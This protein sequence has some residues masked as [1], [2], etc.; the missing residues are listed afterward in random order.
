[1]QS[2]FYLLEEGEAHQRAGKLNLAL[3]RFHGVIKACPSFAAVYH[4]VL[5]GLQLFDDHEEDQYDFHSYTMRKHTFNAYLLFIA[6]E[7]TLRKHPGYARAALAA[8]KASMLS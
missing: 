5:N 6:W 7:D 1:M 4:N 2:L 3:K 8:S